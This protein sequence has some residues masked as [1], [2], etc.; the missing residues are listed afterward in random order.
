MAC[1]CPSMLRITYSLHACF[2]P[3]C[4]SQIFEHACRVISNTILLLQ[5]AAHLLSAA[6]D[7]RA[8][9][10]SQL[11]ITVQF[12]HWLDV[13]VLRHTRCTPYSMAVF[14][15]RC[16][17]VCKMVNARINLLLRQA[18]IIWQPAQ[19]PRSVSVCILSIHRH[20]PE[21][22]LGTLGGHVHPLL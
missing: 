10:L 22:G 20:T 1:M 2:G 15:L 21:C 7:I 4:S 12:A 6:K 18:P 13:L 8:A 19:T 14:S 16:V 17:L 3:D 9:H 11:C 5:I